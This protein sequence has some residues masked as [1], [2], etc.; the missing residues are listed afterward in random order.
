[1][2]RSS[3]AAPSLFSTASG[4]S[5]KGFVLM[6]S[7][8]FLLLRRGCVGGGAPLESSRGRLEERGLGFCVLDD[9]PG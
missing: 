1:M 5:S 4:S 6:G 8:A 3:R 2:M 7:G 9:A